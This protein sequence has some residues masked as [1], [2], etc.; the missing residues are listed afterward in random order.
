MRLAYRIGSAVEQANKRDDL[1]ARR[2]V[3][4]GVGYRWRREAPYIG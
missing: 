4:T 1:L 3:L 2:R